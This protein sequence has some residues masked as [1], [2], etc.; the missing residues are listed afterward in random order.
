MKKLARAHDDPLMV[1]VALRHTRK[2]R[3][4]G[5]AVRACLGALVF[6]ALY[7]LSVW[8]QSGNAGDARRGGHVA[9][10]KCVA[11]HALDG[12]GTAAQYP[13]IAGQDPLYLYQQLWAFKTGARKSPLMSGIAA[14]L[15]DREMADAA[16][17]YG[18]Q[19]IWPDPITDEARVAAGGRV[20]YAQIG[21][22]MFGSC[23]ACHGAGSGGGPMMGGGMMGGRSMGGP[24]MG[25]G[26]MGGGMMG[27]GATGAIP[28][29][30]GQHAAY[31]VDQLNRFATGERQGAPMGRVAATL[32]ERD[33]EAVAAYLST[34]P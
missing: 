6:G 24:M 22:G 20:F 10:A 21:P 23:A 14:P 28:K 1:H 31:I 8:A 3:D 33:R 7:P 34:R 30:N 18:R 17:Y 4:N 27:G 13:K 11:C 16:A 29:L 12:N 9:Q 5:L 15:A 2:A 32:S 19:S 26:M 25:G